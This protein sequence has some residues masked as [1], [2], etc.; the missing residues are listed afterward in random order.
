MNIG[1]I[2]PV[3]GYS[4]V[5]QGNLPLDY[6]KSLTHLYQPLIG[7]KAV[8]LYQT[9]LHEIDLQQENDFQ[10]HHTLMNYLNISL[11]EIYEERLKLEGIGL[12]K[13]FEDVN[14]H[15]TVYHYVLRNPFSPSNFFK[16]AMLSQLLYHHIGNDKFTLLKSHYLKNEKQPGGRN[17]TTSF[18]DVFETVHSDINV[19]QNI[20]HLPDHNGPQLASVDFTWMEQILKSRMIPYKRVLTTDNKRIIN[21]MMQ[22]YGLTEYDIE[23]CVLWALTDENKLD[24]EEFKEA[25]HDIFKTS[26]SDTTVQLESKKL[27]QTIDEQKIRVNKPLTKEEQLITHLESIS[28][29]QLLEDLSSGN[30]ASEQD[31]KVIREIM[32]TQGLPS[33]VMNVLIHY[34]LLQTN[35]KLS[36]AY[37]EK[38]ASHWSRANLKT[39]QEAMEFAK[40][41]RERFRIS[42][43]KKQQK[44]NVNY[45]KRNTTSEVIPD[46]FKERKQ[47]PNVAQNENNNMD[48]EREKEE[49]QALLSQ[50]ANSSKNN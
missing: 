24:I 46:W 12:L 22:L 25:C 31:L 23:K 48:L 9:L 43:E 7:M 44:N 45:K 41:E 1:K 30:H 18:N 47:K 21:Q 11:V 37:L 4:V 28:P 32:T 8:M 33:P 36:K 15:Q 6:A 19:M 34:V 39:A 20:N 27:V 42:M 13:T 26:R 38:I 5:L 50:Y 16:D 10:T 3:D 40:K 35:M 14:E 29:K 2:L 17:I 49:I